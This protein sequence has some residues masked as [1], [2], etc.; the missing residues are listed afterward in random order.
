MKKLISILVLVYL[1]TVIYCQIPKI[2]WQRFFGTPEDDKPQ[3]ILET[4]NGYMLGITLYTDGPGITNFHGAADAWIVNIDTFGNIIWE[5]CFGGSEGDQPYKIIKSIND[6]YYLFNSTNST[7]G[8]ITCDTNFGS[9][10]FWI[11]KIDGE[12][13]IIWDHCYGS[14]TTDYA[15][16][17]VATPDGGLL[18]MGR[19]FSQGGDVQIHYGSYDVWICK[20]DSLGTLE[21]EKTIGNETIDNALSLQLTSDSTF[22]FIGG[23]YESGGMIDCEVATTGEGADLWLVEMDL[24]GNLLNQYCYGGSYYDLG[25]DFEKINDGYILASSTT[26]ND[27]DVSGIHGSPNYHED[28]WVVRINEQGEIIWQNCLG[29]L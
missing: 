13:N 4:E 2:K 23:Y 6:N 12:G 1:S 15:R 9:S 24:K 27:G 22:A 17:A 5:K 28:I 16:D 19:I 21:W 10:D 11:V 20:I 7:D 18:F 8:D 29:E 3:C 26:S 14:P 25:Q